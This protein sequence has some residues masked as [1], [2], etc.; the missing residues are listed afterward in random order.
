MAVS[1]LVVA[2][3]FGSA[4][5]ARADV[6][7]STGTNVQD[8]SNRTSGTQSGSSKTGDSVGGQV[9]GVVSSGRTSV[10]ARNTSD[11]SDVT[12]GD[13]R[14]SNSAGTF[15]GLNDTNGGDTTI[16]PADVNNASADNLQ[17]GDNRTTY[18]QSANATTGDGVGGEVI[19]VVT[20][21]GGSASV[22]AANTTRD[23]DVTTGDARSDND[24]AAFVGLNDTNGGD[25]NISDVASATADN[26]QD[27]NNRLTGRQS[28]NATSGDGVGGQVLGVVS[29]GAASLDASNTTDNSDV[30]TGDSHANN[31]AGSFV[32]LNDTNGGDVGISDV[33]SA[34]AV[35][36]QDGDNSKT[37]TQNASAASG[38][39]VAGQVSGVVTSAGGSASVVVANTSTNIDSTSGDSRFNN[40]DNGF[41]GQNFTDGSDLTIP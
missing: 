35:N 8:G 21:A 3:A 22:V 15:T 6:S 12:S 38:D 40:S 2:T 33:A 7:N 31:D 28:A 16:G 37:L 17:D 14:G 30:T 34:S 13:A 41:V 10:D 9:T 39:G 20:A 11:N 29:A 1:A 27:G 25:V 23:T 24:L 32:G 36:L 26:L 19:G 5:V 18:N 4:A